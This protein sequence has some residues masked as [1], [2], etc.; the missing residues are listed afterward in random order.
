MALI[1]RDDDIFLTEAPNSGQPI[2]DFEAFVKAHEMIAAAGA[3]HRLAIIASEIREHPEMF[4][5]IQNHLHEC[6]LAVHGW[7]HADYSRW[8]RPAWIAR[9]L[10]DAG[11]AIEEFFA[12]KPKVFVP[13]W[14]KISP[15]VRKACASLNLTIDTSPFV[16]HDEARGKTH[17]HFHY[18]N[19]TQVEAVRQWLA[20]SS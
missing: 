10:R 9:S 15:H 3:T 14:N 13:P 20:T 18:W 2:Y 6:E 12:L 4:K 17:V 8:K 11:N 16:Q 1:V 5:Y 19:S 7:T